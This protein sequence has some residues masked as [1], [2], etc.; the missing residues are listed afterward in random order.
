MN[1]SAEFYDQT[2]ARHRDRFLKSAQPKNQ[3]TQWFLDAAAAT[4]PD[5]ESVRVLDLGTGNGYVLKMLAT[6]YGKR[7]KMIGVDLSPEMVVQAKE[8]TAGISSIE[9]LEHDNS[10][11]PY[12][13]NEFDLITN[14]L[15]TH[16]SVQ[17][18]FRLLKPG[19]TFVFKEYGLGKGL[20]EISRLFPDRIGATDPLT[21]IEAMRLAGFSTYSYE[22]FS[23]T[24]VHSLAETAQILS[25]APIIRDYNETKDLPFIS[26]TLGFENIILTSDPFIIHGT[27]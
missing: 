14:K 13:E 21:Y 26:A 12:P 1:S 4:I 22:Q 23:F 9:I 17:E 5:S 8:Y 7:A 24:A 25:A 15:S 3:S 20:L 16:F 2:T 10:S 6:Q 19:G 27:K 18:V 11:L